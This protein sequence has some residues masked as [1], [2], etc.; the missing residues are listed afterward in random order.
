MAWNKLVSKIGNVAK[1]VWSA[2]NDP[3]TKKYWNSAK[4]ILKEIVKN[5]L[6]QGI[7]QDVKKIPMADTV[8]GVAGQ[9]GALADSIVNRPDTQESLQ[10]FA[11]AQVSR[12]TGGKVSPEMLKK[13]EQL[14]VAGAKKVRGVRRA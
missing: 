13:V 2:S 5:P 12:K 1:K 10:D 4:G 8:L 3:A 7:I 6:A 11:N 14:G 9:A